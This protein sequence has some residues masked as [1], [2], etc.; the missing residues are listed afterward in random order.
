[1]KHRKLSLLLAVLL[2]VMPAISCSSDEPSDDDTAGGDTTVGDT[3]AAPAGEASGIPADLDLEGE[4]INIWYTTNASAASETF[5]DL[6]PEQTGDILDDA[7]FEANVAVEEK[8]KCTLEYFN[9]GVKTSNTGTA[10]QTMLMAD[11]TTYDLYN[12]IQWTSAK[13]VLEGIFLNIADAPYISFDKPW[14]DGVFMEAMS[15]GESKL[16]GLVGDCTVDRTR[17]LNAMY[18]NKQMYEDFFGDPDGLYEEVLDMTWTHD[19]LREISSMVY[20]D[21][22]N[23]GKADRGDILGYCTND[24]NNIDSF[25]YGANVKITE[26]DENDHPVIILNNENTV[27][28]LESVY[29]LVFETDGV[30][31]SGPQY[32]QDVLNRNK[33]IEGTSMFHPGFFY[34]AEA[35]RDMKADYGIVPFPLLDKNQKNY[36]S[37]IHDII[38][39]MFLPTNCQKVDAVCAALEELAFQGY[40]N[41]LPQYYDVLLKNKYAR[42]DNSAQMIEIIRSNTLTEFG[43]LFSLNTIASIQRLQIQARS[44][45]FASKYASLIEGAQT[46]LDDYIE[47]FEAID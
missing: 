8:L 7:I 26:R 6:D 20:S 46:V 35:M 22:N 37:I 16:Y 24:Y 11:D 12:T 28:A 42:D 23:D 14:W 9:S 33:F 15:I 40:R 4:V 2:A 44:S 10:I 39:I 3:T 31:F 1:M 29:R 25:Y 21:V 36:Q 41:V 38:R 45:D 5:V 30:Y 34:T 19:R 43:R 18:Y 27:N 17:C 13:L 32:E 47:L